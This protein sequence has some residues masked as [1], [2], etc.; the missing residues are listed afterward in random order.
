MPEP[1][2]PM[3]AVVCPASEENEMSLEHGGVGAGVVEP[4]VAQ[5]ELARFGSS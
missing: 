5:L 1:V 4:D 3:I 2:L